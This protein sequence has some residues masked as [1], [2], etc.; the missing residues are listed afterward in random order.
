MFNAVDSNGQTALHWAASNNDFDKAKDLIEKMSVDEICLCNSDNKY[1]ALHLAAQKGAVKI[2][3]LLLEKGQGT[4]A[5]KVDRHGQTALH[6]CSYSQEHFPSAEAL[7][8][9][10][11]PEDLSIQNNDNQYTVLH[12]A[13]QGGNIT[14]IDLLVAKGGHGLT[15][16][17]DQ[18]G[19]TALH[20]S[21]SKGDY[22][23]CQIL[24]KHMDKSDIN[25]K[26]QSGQTARDFAI[27]K[28]H[29]E[30]ISLLTES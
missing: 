10:M 2:I 14:L 19:Q 1:T 16:K 18:Y 30:I 13:A 26:A 24:C 11:E 23:A 27:A 3:N 6:W 4:L 17:I 21:A 9:I 20:W 5:N 29:S 25:R 8:R 12:L 15:C 22:Q 28:N 7:V